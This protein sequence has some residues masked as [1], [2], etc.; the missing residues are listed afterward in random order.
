MEQFNRIESDLDQLKKY[1]ESMTKIKDVSSLAT[2]P[3]DPSLV[4]NLEHLKK[5]KVSQMIALLMK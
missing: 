5:N 4:N 3:Y 1:F 2:Q